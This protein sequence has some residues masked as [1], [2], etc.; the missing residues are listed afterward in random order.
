MTDENSVR[1]RAEMVANV[2]A[3]LCTRPLNHFAE[4]ARLDGESLKDAIERYEID[5]AWHVLGSAR[6][7][8]E[9]VA[10]LHARYK[11]AVTSEQKAGVAE[12]LRQASAK[13]APDLLM[14]FDNDV[15]AQLAGL[16]GA[17]WGLVK[18]C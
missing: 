7:R 16:L 15:P 13:Q 1:E 6:M 18:D 14:S 12:I 3:S 11:H 17:Q 2:V 10:M 5:Y 4:E 8:D 9:T